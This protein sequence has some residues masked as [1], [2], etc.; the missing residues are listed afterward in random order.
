MSGEC[1]ILKHLGRKIER[2]GYL[3]VGGSPGGI[4]DKLQ[5]W[6]D[7]GKI[8]R[9]VEPVCARAHLIAKLRIDFEPVRV[10]ELL[11]RREIA[12]GFN[13]GEFA[14]KLSHR[15]A[16]GVEIDNPVE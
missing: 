4:A 10:D 1:R 9:E 15:V 7:E 14:E 16:R 5:L 6:L 11:R 12:F 2:V 3:H 8:K 13:S